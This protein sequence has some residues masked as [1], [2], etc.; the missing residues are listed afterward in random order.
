MF[1]QRLLVVLLLLPVGLWALFTSEVTFAVFI[2]IICVIAGFEFAK[3]FRVGGYKPANFAI[4]GAIFFALASVT[5]YQKPLPLEFL[6]P[7]I[8][9]A[10]A[11][12]LKSFER[13]RDEAVFD[14]TISL[15]GILYL[16]VLASYFM[17]LR[18][19]SGGE[20]W[21]LIVLIC[22]WWADT[23][24]YFIG[25]NFGKHALA[26]R[27]SP[28]KTWEGYIGGIVM[29]LIGSPLLLYGFWALNLPVE[30]TITIPRVM[31]LAALLG[32]LPAF[33]DLT[34]SMLK[35]Y[36]KV[37]DSGKILA[38]HGG[39]LDRIDSWLWAVSIGYYLV[40]KFFLS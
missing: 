14:L 4:V 37:K 5:Y 36:F 12:H 16:G 25:K 35:R 15:S 29:A 3:M 26:P 28:K 39:M 9:L 38:G 17:A 22:V 33:G 10:A 2:T 13:G 1:L 21:L 32:V 24:A 18:V 19:L 8:L 11:F 40:T 7:F 30:E 34:I 27:L 23:G 20:W 31:I 6:V